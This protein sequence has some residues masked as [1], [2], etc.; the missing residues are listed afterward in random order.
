M[1]WIE[2]RPV[3]HPTNIN[4]TIYMHVCGL[5]LCICKISILYRCQNYFDCINCG[6]IRDN[7][8]Y[9]IQRLIRFSARYFWKCWF[10]LEQFSRKMIGRHLEVRASRRHK[11][12]ESM[13]LRSRYSI[14]LHGIASISVADDIL[15]SVFALE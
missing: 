9:F 13:A 1:H 15:L 4:T 14:S 5:C 12:M 11:S 3:T 10:K 8:P 6:F 7:L 2:R